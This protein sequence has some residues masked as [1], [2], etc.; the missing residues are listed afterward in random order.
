MEVRDHGWYTM[1]RTP[2]WL[3]TRTLAAVDWPRL[4]V[5][6]EDPAD[7]VR[8]PKG[9]KG[10]ELRTLGSLSVVRQLLAAGLVDRLK[11][12]I[13]PLV[14]ARSGLEPVFQG[15]PDNWPGSCCVQDSRQTGFAARIPSRRR[16]TKEQLSRRS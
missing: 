8:P 14:L 11:L 7:F 9:M 12:L 13:C 1:T 2:D 6:H 5:V 4:T 3:C 16:A 15:L 10:S